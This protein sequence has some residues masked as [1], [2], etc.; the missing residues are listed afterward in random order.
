[1]D[2]LGELY[3]SSL[4]ATKPFV[5][6][7]Y[8]LE[9]FIGESEAYSILVKI[10]KHLR[11]N[12]F[13]CSLSHSSFPL[14][15]NK[16]K[17][18][19]ISNDVASKIYKHVTQNPN[20][21][22]RIRNTCLTDSL[23]QTG[24]RRQEILLIRV[25]DVRLALQSELICPMLQL[26]TL[27]TRKELFRVIPVP[28]T[29]LQNLSL[30][31]RRI[32]KKIIEKTIGLNN[33]HGYVFISHSTGKPLSPDTFTTYMHKWASEINLNGQAFA[34]LYRH[35]FITEKFKCLILEHQINNPDTFRQL[36]INTHKFQQI[37]QQWT[38]HTSLE[39]LN[40]YINLAYSDLSNIDQTIENVISK[41]DLALIT[42]KIN[43]LTEFINS[44]DLSSEEKV[45]EITFSLQALASDLKH[46]KK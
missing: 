44:S 31:I 14:P 11:K 28:K 27:K 17:R 40:V 29:Y 19:P 45:F 38:G 34:H 43:I 46:I 39:S 26:R 3:L 18:Y 5:G 6:E 23:E 41:V 8:N 35:R 25:E 37:I 13:S 9:N 20:I 16:Q 33:D 4:C 24:A 10:K 2:L 21:G 12:R 15:S 30:Y 32:R 22:L 36:L 42:E 1:M 7:L